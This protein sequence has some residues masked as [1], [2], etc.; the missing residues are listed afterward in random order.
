MPD[1]AKDSILG[2]SKSDAVTHLS[3]TPAMIV[4]SAWIIGLLAIAA[5]SLNRR[6]V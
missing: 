6:D 1:N 2:V 5:V 4:V 3:Q